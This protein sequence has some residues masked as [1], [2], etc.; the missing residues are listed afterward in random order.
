LHNCGRRPGEPWY[1]H[2]E[3]GGNHRLTE[4]SAAVALGGLD[5]LPGQ[6]ARREASASVLD[7][8]LATV[9]GLRPMVRDSRVDV[10]AHHLYLFRYD[11]EAFAGLDRNR[12]V[13]ALRHHGIPASSGYPTPLYQQPVFADLRF[14]RRATGWSPERPATRY[15]E[16]RL[17]VCERACADTV[18][19]PQ[20]LLLAPPA[21]MADVVAAVHEV[22]RAAIGAAP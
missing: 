1:S 13:A 19:L 4:W 5:R 20:S 21:E 6:L 10:H 8:E 14:D 22:R 18:W 12:F 7:T 9:D 2:F 3:L 11:Q 16:L 17:P 15:G